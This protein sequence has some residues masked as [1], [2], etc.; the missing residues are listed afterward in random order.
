M[1]PTDNKPDRPTPDGAAQLAHELANL[2]DGSLRHLGLAIDTLSHARPDDD[3]PPEGEQILGRLQ[4]TD[5]AM[6]QMASLIHAWMNAAP[7]PRELFEQ[8]QTLGQSLEQVV[9]VH[10]PSAQRHGIEL[11]LKVETA[12]AALP[13][14]P[15]FPVIANAILNSIEAIAASR[16]DGDTTANRISVAARLEAGLVWLMVSDTGPGLSPQ[17]ID[18]DGSLRVGHST[19]PDGHGLGLTL[20]HQVARSLRGKLELRP[21]P[22]GGT[23]LTLRYPA[24]SL[25]PRAGTDHEVSNA[26][27][28]E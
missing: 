20:S 21:R 25:A 27:P 12:A 2:L 4:T 19:K 7:K 3:T 8:S 1:S 24:S 23:T 17:M 5:R 11:T 28:S 9:E 22:E 6:R 18:E 15:V 13:A 14:G 26:T 10:E 16:T